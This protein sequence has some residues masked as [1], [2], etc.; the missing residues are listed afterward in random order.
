MPV[1]HGN[2]G[3]TAVARTLTI[4]KHQPDISGNDL[5]QAG[6][7]QGHDATDQ[8]MRVIERFTATQLYFAGFD[9]S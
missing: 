3:W 4:F 8:A 6:D 7:N 2:L 9:T 1:P 5:D